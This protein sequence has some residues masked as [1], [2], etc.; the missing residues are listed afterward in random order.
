MATPIDDTPILEGDEAVEFLNHMLDQPS[1]KQKRIRKKI[2]ATF[3]SF[4]I[5]F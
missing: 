2:G 4:L 1:E 5:F 3:C